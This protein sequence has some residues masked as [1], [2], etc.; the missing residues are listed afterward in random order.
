VLEREGERE[1]ERER[2][3]E[4]EKEKK[5]KLK[6]RSLLLLFSQF[7]SFGK[8]F[9]SNFLFSDVTTT[10][11]QQKKVRRTRTPSF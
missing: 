2:K 4:R 3:S 10:N 5:K 1:R 11:L 6:K 9:V 8:S 7:F